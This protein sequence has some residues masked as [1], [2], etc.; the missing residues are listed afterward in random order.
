MKEGMNAP[1]RI[2]KRRITH[3][4][5]RRVKRRADAETTAQC[6]KVSHRFCPADDRERLREERMRL[7]YCAICRLRGPSDESGIINRI[8]LG[9]GAAQRANINYA[10]GRGPDKRAAVLIVAGWTGKADHL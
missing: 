9:E 2:V 4:V 6:S 8:S 3:Y 5:I 7:P 10:S 1:I